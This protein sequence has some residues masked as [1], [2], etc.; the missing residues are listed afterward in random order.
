[1]KFI[2]VVLFIFLHEEHLQLWMEISLGVVILLTSGFLTGLIKLTA[3]GRLM[4]ACSSSQGAEGKHW[5]LLS[6]GRNGMELCQGS[7]RER[8]CPREQWAQHMV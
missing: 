6:A 2:I 4:A 8:F 3:Y 1:M 7:I 5:A